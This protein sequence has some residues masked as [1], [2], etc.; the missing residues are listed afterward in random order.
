MV[1]NLKAFIVVLVF[2]TSIFWVFQSTIGQFTLKEDYQRR[3]NVWLVLTITAFLSGS[4]WIFVLIATPVLIWAARKDA[5]P[6]ALYLLLFQVVPSVPVQIPVVGINQLFTMDIYRLLSFVV[7]C[8]A[9]LRLAGTVRGAHLKRLR[10]IDILIVAF[11]LMQV[12]LF[13]P[14]D[15]PHNEFTAQGLTGMLRSAFLFLIDTYV[16]YF[17]VSRFCTDRRKIEEALACFCLNGFILAVLGSFESFRHWLLYSDLTAL[18]SG[19]IRDTFYLFRGAILRAQ[20]STNHPLALGYLLALA[21]GFWLHLGSVVASRKRYIFAAGLLALGLLAAYSRGPWIGALVIYF[22][23]SAFRPGRVTRVIGAVTAVSVL[24]GLL[25]VSPLGNRIMDVIPAF[26]GSVDSGSFSYRARLASRA[27]QLITQ[28]PWL[29][30]Q[31]AYSHMNDL[32][33]G[34]GIIDIV[35]TY[36]SVTLFYG[37][38]GLGLFLGFI[39][40]GTYMA[41]RAQR[42]IQDSDRRASNLGASLLGSMA[43]TIVMIASCSLI[44]GYEKMLY[45]LVGMTAAYSGLAA[46]VAEPTHSGTDEKP[47]LVAAAPSGRAV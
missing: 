10:R 12:L 40:G 26:G 46:Q 34:Q 13:V 21:F 39:L 18:W 1:S 37:F 6:V 23:F 31:L 7:L 2:A 30:D 9:A 22:V 19:D 45:V 8:P 47:A 3:R 25:L 15:L 33:Q 44:F 41:L 29:G 17:V 28:H 16:V 42:L 20:V 27:W 43:G 36:V 5:N 32:R 14:P 38:V 4:F 35:N 11:G 24:G